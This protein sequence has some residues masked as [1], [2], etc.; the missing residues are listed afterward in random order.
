[1]KKTFNPLIDI[2]L[3][4]VIVPHTGGGGYGQGEEPESCEYN[5]ITY[6]YYAADE[7]NEFLDPDKWQGA[8][9]YDDDCNYY[10]ANPGSEWIC[11]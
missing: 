1:M 2:T 5:G 9:Y 3:A 11:D 7:Q 8:G 10:G 6:Y 4:D